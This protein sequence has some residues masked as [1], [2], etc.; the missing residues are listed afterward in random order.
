MYQKMYYVLSEELVGYTPH[1]TNMTILKIC[2]TNES[3]TI[4]YVKSEFY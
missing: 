2:K 4:I 1:H 3:F